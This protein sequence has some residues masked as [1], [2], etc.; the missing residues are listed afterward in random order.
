MLSLIHS[1]ESNGGAATQTSWRLTRARC[2]Q[3]A[4]FVCL[5]DL[6][7]CAFAVAKATNL[8]VGL[9]PNAQSLFEKQQTAALKLFRAR[10]ASYSGIAVA[11]EPNVLRLRLYVPREQ[12]N[13][14]FEL[15]RVLTDVFEE[16]RPSAKP[17]KTVPEE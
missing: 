5:L 8:P 12:V 14:V 13:D 16:N 7:R 11:F 15:Y 17:A 4:N 3:K 6:A 10:E 1:F 2:G 9:D